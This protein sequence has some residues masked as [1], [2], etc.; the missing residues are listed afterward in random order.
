VTECEQSGITTGGPNI[1]GS[2]QRRAGDEKMVGERKSR[3][4]QSQTREL[5]ISWTTSKSKGNA[6]QDHV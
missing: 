1:K 6:E 2:E 4:R 5:Q 3:N